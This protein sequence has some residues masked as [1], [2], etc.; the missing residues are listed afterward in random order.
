MRKLTAGNLQIKKNLPK[1]LTLGLIVLVS[2]SAT[3]AFAFHYAGVRWFSSTVSVTYDLTGLNN[4]KD[5]NGNTI[6]WPT[7]SAEIDKARND[8]NNLPSRFFLDRITSSDHIVTSSLL[9]T[10]G[11]I[12]RV[13]CFALIW[14]IDCDMRF[15][16][17]YKWT[18]Q[19]SSTEPY[20]ISAVSRHEWGHFVIF[21]DVTTRTDT[22]MYKFY[23]I[24]IYSSIKAV[25]SNEL[26][27][28]YG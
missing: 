21:N 25:D 9:G 7:V 26:T 24:N 27:Q 20:T 13:D 12:A 16:S 1:I 4:L 23:N 5:S 8:W 22:V 18:T 3:A 17:S 10:T 19:N 14:V 28:I 2:A 15:N 11:P 6:G